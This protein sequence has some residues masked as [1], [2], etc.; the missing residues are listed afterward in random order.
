MCKP[1]PKRL[2]YLLLIMAL[3]A[4]TNPLSAQLK[5][6]DTI[7]YNHKWQMC[8]KPIAFYYRVGILATLDNQWYF[9]GPQKDYD[10]NNALLMEGNYSVDGL[11]DGIFKF[12]YSNGKP[13]LLARY[14]MGRIFGEWSWFYPDGSIHAVISFREDTQDFYFLNFVNENGASTMTNGTGEFSWP[15]VDF[16]TTTSHYRATGSFNEG[17]RVGDWIFKPVN[18]IIGNQLNYRE[19]YKDDKL[20]RTVGDKIGGSGQFETHVKKTGFSFSPQHLFTTESMQYDYFFRLNGDSSTFNNLASYLIDHK[21]TEITLKYKVFDTAFKA[22]IQKLERYINNNI[23]VLP[24]KD[25]NCKLQFKIGSH[26]SFED[27]NFTGEGVDS[28]TRIHIP[29]LLSKFKDMEM[30]G[31]QNIA[32][33]TNITVYLYLMDFE[34]VLPNSMSGY[35]S[36]VLMLNFE[37]REK[38]SQYMHQHK[39]EIKNLLIDARINHDFFFWDIRPKKKKN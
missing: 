24:D 36:R 12:Y 32:I 22:V 16:E 2:P 9:L 21:P 28:I 3:L 8:E 18:S 34:E 7:Y 30:P 35:N 14:M 29:F 25:I 11:K 13:R 37:P 23:R 27:I 33:E 39:K 31:D 38:L 4:Y 15:T 6:T 19:E 17:K 10:I 5:I 20:L 1:K 26:G